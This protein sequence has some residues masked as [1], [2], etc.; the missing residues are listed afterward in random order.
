VANKKLIIILC[1]VALS[2]PV[3]VSAADAIIAKSPPSFWPVVPCGLN[4]QPKA[5]GN[6]PADSKGLLE[7]SVWDYTQPCNHCLLIVLF[8]NLIDMVIK[9]LVPILGTFFFLL[10]GFMILFGADKPGRIGDGKKLMWNTAIGIAIILS[11]YLITNFILK[12]LAGDSDISN[13]WYTITC[14]VSTLEEIT[15]G[16]FPITPGGPPTVPALCNNPQQLASSNNEPYPK[17]DAPALTSLINCIKK[18]LAGQ[19][20]GEISTFDKSYELCNYTRGAKTCT[21]KCSHTVNSCHYGGHSG[22]QGALAV[23]FGNETIGNQIIQAATQSCGAKSARCE[24][25]AGA[26]VSCSSGS[27]ANHVHV[28]AASCDAN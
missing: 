26:N 15:E 7:K 3:F 4:T 21:S 11:S 14:K 23:D 8:K 5:S 27:G 12:S 25:A 9:G 20:L 19:N 2:A 17:Q 1:L 10:G 16:T 28:T 6:Q 24:N 13:N 18:E 22:N